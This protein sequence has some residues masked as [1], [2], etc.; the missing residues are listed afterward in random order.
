MVVIFLLPIYRMI[1]LLVNERAMKTKDMVRSMGIG[2]DSYWLSWFL[3]Y[4]IGLTLVTFLQAVLLTY[5]VFK[6][7]ELIPVFLVLWLYGLSLFGYIAF[8]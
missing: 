8:I 6:F 4:L 3:Y 5:G 1:S 7:S 2:E